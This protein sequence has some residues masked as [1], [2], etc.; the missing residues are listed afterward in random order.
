MSCRFPGGFEGPAMFWDAIA[1]GRCLAGRIP[2]ER[3]DAAAL[4]ATAAS[5]RDDQKVRMA[6]GCFMEGLDLFDAGFFNVSPAEARAMDPQQR[7]LLEYAYRAFHDAGETKASLAGRK[8]GVFVAM[9][10]PDAIEVGIRA[11]E[12]NVVYNATRA[13]NATAAG[14]IARRVIGQ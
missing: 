3:W 1:S 11:G 6:H 9:S 5:L 8:V 13:S 12:S 7:L 2:P 14:R 4:A 10:E